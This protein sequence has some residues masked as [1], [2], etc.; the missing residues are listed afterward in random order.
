MNKIYFTL[1]FFI[2][3]TML[4][5]QFNSKQLGLKEEIQYKYKTK[6]II[7][8]TNQKII[9]FI[10]DF[11]SLGAENIYFE[12]KATSF[13]KSKAKFNHILY[14]YSND[15]SAIILNI[16]KNEISVELLKLELNNLGLN[17]VD[18]FEI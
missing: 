9:C 3:F 2:S 15:K 8:G 7:K 11:N 6:E 5:A 16:D 10:Y 4:N 18:F 14:H 13:L 17:I 12:Q 1:L